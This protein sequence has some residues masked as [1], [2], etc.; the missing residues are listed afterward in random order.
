MQNT[1]LRTVIA[2]T[3]IL[4]LVSAGTAGGLSQQVS[5]QDE[6]PQP[7]NTIKIQGTGPVVNYTF[8]AA[9]VEPAETADIEDN[10]DRVVGNTV[11]GT[12]G[13]GGVDEYRFNGPI[14]SFQS[15]NSDVL[16]IWINGQQVDPSEIGPDPTPESRIDASIVDFSPERGTYRTGDTQQAQ[17]T[18]EN[19]GN[20]EHTFFVG[21][22]T[23]DPSDGIRN[24]DDTT[25]T[26]VTLAPSEQR[27]VSVSWTV[28]ADAPS[29]TYSAGTA[30]WKETG[31]LETRLDR[32]QR[33]AAFEVI[34]ETPTDTPTETPTDTPTETPTDTPTDT[35][36]ATPE[37]S[38][39]VLNLSADDE[40][41]E[42]NESVE[43]TATVENTGSAQRTS[44]VELVTFGEVVASQNLTLAPG[45]VQSVTFTHAYEVPGD[46]T[47]S[48]GDQSAQIEVESGDLGTPNT[49]T[50]SPPPLIEGFV[51]TLIEATNGLV[52]V[53]GVAAVIGI[54]I[55]V[56]M[57]L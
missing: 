24:N 34:T 32:E 25:G 43:I 14:R 16:K 55:V 38:F 42:V 29:G 18:V 27:T 26:T 40:T 11:S 31:D 28:E 57:R 3:V 17:V 22:I 8:Q 56:I 52:I 6:G 51:A 39:S 47:V 50:P 23:I 44:T 2:T 4:T 46:Y 19:T 1:L 45:A 37:P 21:Y 7:E 53:V 33:T 13:E 5:L 15:E 36:T 49:T 41:I 35:L 30:I 10:T 20:R 9:D 48:V 12:A 54:G